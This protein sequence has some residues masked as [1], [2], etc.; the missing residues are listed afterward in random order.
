MQKIPLIVLVCLLGICCFVS[1]SNHSDTQDNP[2]VIEGDLKDKAYEKE[3]EITGVIPLETSDNCMIGYVDRVIMANDQVFIL[4]N[5]RRKSMLCF[6]KSGNFKWETTFGKGPGEVGDPTA[7]CLKYDSTSV[8]LFDQGSQSFKEFDFN[9]FCILE[10]KTPIRFIED[11]YSLGPD[12]ILVNHLGQEISK[13]DERMKPIFSLCT[14][15]YST[16]HDFDILINS[17]QTLGSINSA[18]SSNGEVFCISPYSYNIYEL[19]PGNYKAQVRYIVDFGKAGLTEIQLNNLSYSE[20]VQLVRF[21][22]EK[23]FGRLFFIAVTK[24]FIALSVEYSQSWY[25][26]LYSFKDKKS[27]SINAY[28]DGNFLPDLRIMGINDE[29]DLFGLVEADVFVKFQQTTGNYSDMNIHPEGNP[30][31]VSFR[32]SL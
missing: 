2:I 27:Y 3:L 12:T 17:N 31:L 5:Y 8:I 24:D 7:I 19:N 18:T 32:I 25:S 16:V 10:R 20:L 11:F 1:C 26:L 14:E 22:Q 4:D 9:G 30:L 23:I 13:N 29:G 21:G 15:D 28:M 6:D